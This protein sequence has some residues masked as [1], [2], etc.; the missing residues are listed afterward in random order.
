MTPGLVTSGP[1]VRRRDVSVEIFSVEADDADV[2]DEWFALISLIRRHDLPDL[3]PLCPVHSGGRFQW[4][5]PGVRERTWLARVEG[6]AV[7]V[8]E[9]SLSYVDNLANADVEVQVHPRMRRT[10]L[11]RRLLG[12]VLAHCRDEGRTTVIGSTVEALPGGAPRDH[13]GHAFAAAVGASPAR[14][15][16]RS[17]LDLTRFNE[18]LMSDLLADAWTQASGYSLVQWRERAPERYVADVARLDSRLLE[19]APTGD[20]KIEPEAIDVER[21]RAIEQTRLARGDRCFHTGLRHDA[22]DAL[23]AWTLMVVDATIDHHGWQQITIVDPA[24]RGHRLGIIAKL[25]NLA[26][27][28]A[29]TPLLRQI[30]TWTAATNA[31]MIAINEQIGFQPVDRW[32]RWQRHL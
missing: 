8:A 24:H 14:Q 31:H 25:E 29:G 26:H 12:H 30:D 3:P 9:A 4:P 19:D 20:L 1:A 6:Q 17:R 21:T 15:D 22:T 16:V 10:G 7:G 5:W 23:V 32:L 18:D 11:G 13:A 27:V 2:I 28:R